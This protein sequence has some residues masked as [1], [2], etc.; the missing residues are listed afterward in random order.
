MR[1][2][3]IVSLIGLLSV[4]NAFSM[5]VEKK[6]YTMKGVA[7]QFITTGTARVTTG[8]ARGRNFD[9]CSAETNVVLRNILNLENEPFLSE[10]EWDRLCEGF[11]DADDVVCDFSRLHSSTLNDSCG[12]A[13]GQIVSVSFDT[14]QIPMVI[15]SFD[16]GQIVKIKKMQFINFPQCAGLSCKES[17][18]LEKINEDNIKNN[19]KCPTE[20][21]YNH[22]PLKYRTD[23]SLVV[24]TCKW[25]R[26]RPEE[27]K[28][29]I[30]S[31]KKYQMYEYGYTPASIS[32]PVTCSNNGCL[33]ENR[34]AKFFAGFETDSRTRNDVPVLHK[35]RWLA[36]QK[37]T[38]I[39][40]YC[41][42]PP[43]RLNRDLKYGDAR[44]I[45]T[46]TCK[47]ECSNDLA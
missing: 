23:G 1:T 17:N 16:D 28:K 18:I 42:Y 5:I 7:P 14:C 19:M 29:Q 9:Q 21:P 26:K 46:R 31:R 36:R 4:E 43:K 8:T 20:G 37:F 12:Q 10:M 34:N 30:C 15:G 35:C 22:F 24:R 39:V 40:S 25:L 3:S 11:P 38:D 6:F 2:L 41:Y 45:C 33:Q 32:C 47:N 13:G 27:L 44:K